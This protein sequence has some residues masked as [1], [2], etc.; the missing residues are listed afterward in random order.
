MREVPALQAA[1]VFAWCVNHRKV[2]LRDW[3]KRI[4]KIDRDGQ[5]IDY[6]MLMDADQAVMSRIN[7][8]NLPRRRVMR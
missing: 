2:A 7:S 8:F 6:E 5:S 3:Q 4:L 1:D